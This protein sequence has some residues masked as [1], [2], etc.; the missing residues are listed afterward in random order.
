VRLC[1]LALAAEPEHRAALDTYRRAHEQLLAEHGRANFWMTRWLEGEIR[2][3]G[4]RLTR[5]DAT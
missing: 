5:L 2:G 4:N 1:E 3:A